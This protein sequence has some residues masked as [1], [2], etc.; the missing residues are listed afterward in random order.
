MRMI[1]HAF[2]SLLR[3]TLALIAASKERRAIRALQ[4]FDGRTLSDIGI[5]RGEI[6]FAVRHGRPSQAKVVPFPPPTKRRNTDSSRSRERTPPLHV[7]LLILSLVPLGAVLSWGNQQSET[8][9]SPTKGEMRM[10]DNQDW[11][12]VYDFWFP[13]GLENADAQAFRRRAEWWF[14]GG[15]N[16][17]LAPFA[18]T[19]TAA[20]SGRLDHWL[21]TPRGR[22]SLIIVLDQFQRGLFAGKPE[23]YAADAQA[24]RIAE[25]GLRN[26]H[27][28]ALTYAWEKT[29][30]FLPLGHAEG[31]DHLERLY[32]AVALAEDLVVEV[33]A[34][35]KPHYEFS[36]S[37][38]RANRDL[39]ERFGRF[40]HR[41]PML[42]RTSTP[43]E[44]EYL[45]A[46]DFVHMRRPPAERAPATVQ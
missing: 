38:A 34:R 18:H 42:G 11:K 26:G 23:A 37:Q 15:A 32:R 44:V 25:E 1:K 8:S 17:E 4:S 24:L 40:P 27:Y 33:P 35:L 14:G 30:F 45:K 6:E 5:K 22:L 46:G 20:R 28:D 19:L 3:G 2:G 12:T 29:F 7:L 9:V 43:E 39:I 10:N 41:N 13:P 31:P 16:A 36:L 21:A